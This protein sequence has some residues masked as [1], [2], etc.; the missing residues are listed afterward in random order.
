M[1]VRQLWAVWF[2]IA[3]HIARFAVIVGG[4]GLAS[5]IGIDGWYRGLFV[6]VLCCLFAAGLITWLG[7]WRSIGI[8]RPWAGPLA[9]LLLILP[10]A[11]A[12]IRAGWFGL[13]DRSP[14]FA[15]W[16]VSL[17]MVGVNEELISRGAVLSRMSAEFT[18]VP[19]V[20]IT[21]ALFGL[22]H[23]SLFA[24]T[25]RG[26]GDI[27]T[28]VLA[29]ACYGAALAA[30]QYRFHWIWPLILIHATAD[31]TTT[32]ASRDI[33]TAFDVTSSAVF[34]LYGWYVLRGTRAQ[35]NS[36]MTSSA[37]QRAAPSG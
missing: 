33:G 23:L 31:F 37:I 12:L 16:S 20:A 35:R 10:V 7:L 36:A 25:G 5:A 30:F 32:L 11:E 17:L 4:L 9:A 21:A 24:T 3:V 14:G 19:A 8:L 15:L 27:L 6:N 28:N 26:A 1:T 18:G 34:V 13:D 22:Q 29:S 2:G